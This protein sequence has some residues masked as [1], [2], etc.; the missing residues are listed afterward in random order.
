MKAIEQDR[1][2]EEARQKLLKKSTV[3]FERHHKELKNL[4]KKH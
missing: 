3:M 1:F 4:Q 2:N